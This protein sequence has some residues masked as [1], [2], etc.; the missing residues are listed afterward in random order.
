[1]VCQLCLLD[2]LKKSAECLRAPWKVS[3]HHRQVLNDRVLMCLEKLL[4]QTLDRLDERR[5]LEVR[6]RQLAFDLNRCHPEDNVVRYAQLLDLLVG[7]L[8]I[9]I[10]RS[11]QICRLQ[12]SLVRLR[13][14]EHLS[15]TFDHSKVVHAILSGRSAALR[16]VAGE[17]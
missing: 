16:A 3:D 12:V 5:L 2:D 1:M 17:E 4:L 14:H 13:L 8:V 6:V 9:V 7:L 10:F 15:Q 11:L